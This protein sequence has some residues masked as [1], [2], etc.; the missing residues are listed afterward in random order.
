MG[1][2]AQIAI[3]RL[4]AVDRDMEQHLPAKSAEMYRKTGEHALNLFELVHERHFDAL[5]VI[6]VHL[7]NSL[8]IKCTAN[9]N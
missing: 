2:I 4:L 6:S 9:Y 8:I 3:S 5:F 1:V 7:F